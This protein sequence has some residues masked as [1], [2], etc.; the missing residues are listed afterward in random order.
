MQIIPQRMAYP[1]AFT[2]QILSEFQSKVTNRFFFISATSNLETAKS[3][4]M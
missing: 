1:V 3:K 4:K 2:E